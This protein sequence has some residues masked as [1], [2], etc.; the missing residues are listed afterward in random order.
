M[1]GKMLVGS[2][3]LPTMSLSWLQYLRVHQCLWAPGVFECLGASGR[4]V[5]LDA[6]FFIMPLGLTEDMEKANILDPSM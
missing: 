2:I 1:R 6:F 5:F 4:L 3:L